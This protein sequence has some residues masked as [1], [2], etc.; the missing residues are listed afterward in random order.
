MMQIPSGLLV[1]RFGKKAI[2]IP[3][4][5]LFGLGTSIVAMAS[6]LT[7]LYVGSIMT[8]LGCGTFYGGHIP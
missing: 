6:T 8:G 5:I 4:F 7:V 1:D 2:L 3:G